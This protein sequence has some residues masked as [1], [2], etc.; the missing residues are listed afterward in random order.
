MQISPPGVEGSQ[1]DLADRFSYLMRE[2][3]VKILYF[4][5]IT[6]ES[7]FV[8]KAITLNYQGGVKPDFLV[9]IQLTALSILMENCWWERLMMQTGIGSLR[10]FKENN[11]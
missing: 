9:Q 10:K 5:L 1:H 6:T 4:L 7:R 8:K 11:W 2:R 3:A